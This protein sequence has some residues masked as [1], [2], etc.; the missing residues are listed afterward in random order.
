MTFKWLFA[1]TAALMLLSFW[2]AHRA[3]GQTHVPNPEHSSQSDHSPS[4]TVEQRQ[5]SDERE[6]ARI[7]SD[8]IGLPHRQAANIVVRC[9]QTHRSESR[10]SSYY[11]ESYS[12]QSAIQDRLDSHSDRTVEIEIHGECEQMRVRLGSPHQSDEFYPGRPGSGRDRAHDT[13]LDERSTSDDLP[14]LIRT[15]SGWD[16]FLRRH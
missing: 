16:W 6:R 9:R 7:I 2:P 4:Q 5:R 13:W 14:W 1:S 3:I 12:S 15:G 8:L 11:S 10:Q